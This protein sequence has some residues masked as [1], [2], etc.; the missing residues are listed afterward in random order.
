MRI[1]GLLLAVLAVD[2]G[3]HHAAAQRTG[4]VE[5]VASDQIV[6][7]VRAHALEQIADTV[8]FH[9]EHALGVA[10]LQQGER[11]RV[12]QREFLQIDLYAA[13]FLNEPDSIVEQRER[14]QSQEVHLEQAHFFEITHDPLSRDG[15]LIA[16][17]AGFVGLANNALQRNVIGQRA[18][19]DD[20]ARG[21]RAGVA[22]GSF[23]LAGDVN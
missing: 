1:N 5:R 6:D 12:D 13:R 3:V 15:R 21:M 16:L 2:V 17:A 8:G 14:S 4:P 11:G 10:A 7:V 22:V 19:G 9:L 23:E 18:V 20:H